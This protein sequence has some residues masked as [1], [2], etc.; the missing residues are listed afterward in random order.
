M[1]TS[2]GA[3]QPLEVL[4]LE[5]AELEDPDELLEL[6]V[7]VEVAP[8][9]APPSRRTSLVQA[10]ELTVRAPNMKARVNDMPKGVARARRNTA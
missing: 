10:T 5:L 1:G 6:A 7:E 3:K 4:E 2:G 9:L 8:L